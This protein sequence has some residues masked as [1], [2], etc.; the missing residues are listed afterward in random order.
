MQG[1]DSVSLSSGECL[2]LKE[3][4]ACVCLSGEGV[5]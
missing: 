4:R 2:A 5:V 1:V 3:G